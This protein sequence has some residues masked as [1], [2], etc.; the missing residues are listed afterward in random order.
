MGE[1]WN[2]WG[3]VVADGVTSVQQIQAWEPAPHP[4]DDIPA[5]LGDRSAHGDVLGTGPGSDEPR[6]LDLDRRES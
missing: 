6:G 1:V 5:R 4:S 2:F 3:R